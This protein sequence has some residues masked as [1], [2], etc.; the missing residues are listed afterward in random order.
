MGAL[1]AWL[2]S[3]PLVA[4]AST[5]HAEEDTVRA[6][7]QTDGS[8]RTMKALGCGTVGMSMGGGVAV[9]LPL[10]GFE[11]GV[12][13]VDRL[14]LVGRFETVIGVFHY[15][16]VG[17]RFQPFEVGGWSFGTSLLAHYSFF[18]I[19]TDQT[20][21]T[22]TFYSSLEVGASGPITDESELVFGVAGEL[23]FF[24]V[25]VIDDDSRVVESVH[26]DA[27]VVRAAFKT[28]LTDDL[29]GYAQ[30]KLRIP[31]ET[32]VFEAQQL[33]VIPMLEIGGTWTF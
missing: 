32:F 23:D 15:P 13:L 33:Y 10:Y 22:S 2:Y 4:S 9:L 1:K 20:N 14:D 24:H 26:Y 27:T 11:V 31:V 21:F 17:L 29:D 7:A 3:L 19:K 28:L 18:G 6:P 8:L 12:G 25:E 30:L 16:H 5:A